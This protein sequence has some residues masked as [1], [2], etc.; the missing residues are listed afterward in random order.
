MPPTNARSDFARQ[1]CSPDLS[2]STSSD[3]EPSTRRGAYAYGCP[4]TSGVQVRKEAS[5]PRALIL[6]TGTQTLEKH[7]TQP[8][9]SASSANS[10]TNRGLPHSPPLGRFRALHNT[11][12]DPRDRSGHEVSGSDAKRAMCPP[13]GHGPQPRIARR[14]A[15]RL[16]H[17][18]ERES[19]GRIDQGTRDP[20][21]RGVVTGP[22]NEH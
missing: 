19:V 15:P 5:P 8:A 7:G 13:E 10:S 21:L 17:S 1:T 9:A 16:R 12:R 2:P 3:A 11:P 14:T 22:V 20:G 4:P 18:G 6:R